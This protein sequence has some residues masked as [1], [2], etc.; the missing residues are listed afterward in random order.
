MFERRGGRSREEMDEAY[1]AAAE[2]KPL[3]DEIRRSYLLDA[4]PG[5]G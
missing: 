4:G 5:P 1:A 3:P 2:V